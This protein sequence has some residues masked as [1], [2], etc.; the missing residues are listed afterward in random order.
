MSDSDLGGQGLFGNDPSDGSGGAPSG[1]G[2]FT[3]PVVF[4]NGGAT[5][6]PA[7]PPVPPPVRPVKSGY[8]L[9][10]NFVSSDPGSAF[11]K[12]PAALAAEAAGLDAAG[13]A[14]GQYGDREKGW[15]QWTPEGYEWIA[16]TPKNLPIQWQD[17]PKP[18]R[19]NEGGDN[20]TFGTP[21]PLD[22]YGNK[23]FR[24]GWVRP[25]AEYDYQNELQRAKYGG[26]NPYTGSSQTFEEAAAIQ[27]YYNETGLL[28]TSEWVQSY[29]D[30]NYP[31]RGQS[32]SGMTY[33]PGSTPWG[34]GQRSGTDQLS[35]NKYGVLEGPYFN[36]NN[37]YTNARGI[38]PGAP[39]AATPVVVP[40]EQEL[41][42]D[43]STKMEKY[44]QDMLA[45][46]LTGS[47]RLNTLRMEADYLTESLPGITDQSELEKAQKALKENAKDQAIEQANIKA[48]VNAENEEANKT[49]EAL[50]NN[51]RPIT[52]FPLY[53]ELTGLYGD[54]FRVETY[55]QQALQQAAEQEERQKNDTYGGN[56]QYMPPQIKDPQG[57]FSRYVNS[58]GVSQGAQSWLQAQYPTL[59]QGWNGEGSIVD[60]V[61]QRIQSSIGQYEGRFAQNQRYAPLTQSRFIPNVR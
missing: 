17:R 12:S 4:P 29:M 41:A 57:E 35:R 28:P 36:E 7:A 23:D 53:K 46:S 6:P 18:T 52:A 16:P 8:W 20:P 24:F 10:G 1:G 47:T 60:Y 31:R 55:R 2:G 45:S 27:N 5:I 15:Y 54:V 9:N 56:P 43:Y 32:D 37:E 50:I 48:K 25:T 51:G 49:I 3:W 30:A 21:N 19:F 42:D 34:L 44:Y 33:F 22:L 59:A 39:P 58:L 11:Y 13:N 38:N 61:R 40:T 26:A 14:P